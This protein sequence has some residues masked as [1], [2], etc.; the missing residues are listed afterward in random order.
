MAE[1]L[2][3]REHRMDLAGARQAAAQWVLQA[4]EKFDLRCTYEQ[5]NDEDQVSF[6]RPGMTGLLKV[7]AQRFEIQAELGF[8]LGAFKDRI[9]SEIVKNLDALLNPVADAG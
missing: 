3:E 1:I 6:T 5:G 2:I 8:L 4:E 9:E 7:N